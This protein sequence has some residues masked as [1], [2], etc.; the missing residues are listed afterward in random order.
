MSKSLA[1]TQVTG[2]DHLTGLVAAHN[3]DDDFMDRIHIELMNNLVRLHGNNNVPTEWPARLQ[4]ACA[5]TVPAKRRVTALNGL[6]AVLPQS[7]NIVSFGNE[8]D[9][10]IHIM[11][12]QRHAYSCHG[13][14]SPTPGM[15]VN[16]SGSRL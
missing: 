15:P 5:Y 12:P 7:G 8:I 1:L 10:L 16:N 2:R 11:D 4:L 13:N 6:T 3:T 9:G 14:M